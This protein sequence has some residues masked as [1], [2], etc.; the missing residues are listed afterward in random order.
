MG[1]AR[2]IHQSH[3]LAGRFVMNNLSGV[4]DVLGCSVPPPRITAVFEACHP[5]GEAEG[6]RYLLKDERQLR[7]H[8]FHASPRGLRIAN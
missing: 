6:R 5:A 4:A 3:C 7:T 8:F 1:R 2:Q